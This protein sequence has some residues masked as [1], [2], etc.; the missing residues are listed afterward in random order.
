MLHKSLQNHW[1]LLT[2]SS[3]TVTGNIEMNDYVF[4]FNGLGVLIQF[5][6][7]TY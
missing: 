5:L 2:L 4:Q 6:D 3:N 1:I 7:C